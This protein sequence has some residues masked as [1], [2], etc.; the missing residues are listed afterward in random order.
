MKTMLQNFGSILWMLILI[1]ICDLA[2]F[3]NC[4]Q[5][6]PCTVCHPGIDCLPY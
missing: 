2:G 5:N 1:V 6:T 3:R 4:L